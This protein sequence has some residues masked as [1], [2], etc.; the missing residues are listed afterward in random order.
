MEPIK[1]PCTKC[2]Q[3]GL[4]LETPRDGYHIY[5]QCPQCKGAGY[6]RN[7]KGTDT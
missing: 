4:V 2:H 3:S 6:I 1:E 5:R 7:M